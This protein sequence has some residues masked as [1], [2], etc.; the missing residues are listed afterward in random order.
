[1][2]KITYS[3]DGAEDTDY[4]APVTISG[5]GVHE[6]TFYG[7]DNVI[8]R[9]MKTFVFYVDNEGPDVFARFSLPKKG[10]KQ[11]ENKVF[12]TYES[13]T[14]VFLSAT[15]QK[16]GYE[17]MYYSINGTAE[18]SYQ[19]VIKTWRKGNLILLK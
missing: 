17:E 10:Q 14:A 9:N 11:V 6:L 19:G 3:L 18:Q 13:Q 7:Y 16:V 1:M 15:D 5:E 12:D 4:S 2:Q 8:N